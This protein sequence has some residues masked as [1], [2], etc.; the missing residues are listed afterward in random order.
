MLS[1]K[2]SNS[3]VT[4]VGTMLQKNETKG[5]T[6]Y[7]V[8]FTGAFSPRFGETVGLVAGY[9]DCD[10][11]MYDYISSKKLPYSCKGTIIQN[12]KTYQFE[13]AGLDVTEVAK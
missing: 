8:C 3:N 13:I 6:S 9:C 2:N 10:K 1:F 5:T 11:E 4:I 12:A 7:R